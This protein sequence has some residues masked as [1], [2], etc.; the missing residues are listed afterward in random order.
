MN[1]KG[2]TMG[3]T[4]ISIIFIVLIGLTTINFFFT[5]V[6]DARVSLNCASS[7]TISDGTKLL[8]LVLDVTIPYWVYL[9]FAIIIAAIAARM[10]L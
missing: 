8:C 2:Q 7:A 6:S 9:I 10:Y 3:M 5:P 4:I 1:N